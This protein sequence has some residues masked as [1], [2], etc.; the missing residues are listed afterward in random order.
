LG[1]AGQN[2]PVKRVLEE[3]IVKRTIDEKPRQGGLAGRRH[4]E[5]VCDA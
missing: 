3:R 5:V 4:A 2:G 1:A